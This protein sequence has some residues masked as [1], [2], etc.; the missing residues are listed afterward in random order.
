[1]LFS[2]NLKIMTNN[3]VL[4]LLSTLTRSESSNDVICYINGGE[5]VSVILYGAECTLCR[6]DT[7]T[8]ALGSMDLNYNGQKKRTNVHNMT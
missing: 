3:N 4:D 6:N 5:K 1:M 7:S 8:M 2:A